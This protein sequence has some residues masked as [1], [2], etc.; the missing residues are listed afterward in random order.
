MKLSKKAKKV[1]LYGTES[2]TTRQDRWIP[3][4]KFRLFVKDQEGTWI[5]ISEDTELVNPVFVVYDAKKGYGFV[6][7]HNSKLCDFT[8]AMLF[9]EDAIVPCNLICF[10]KE[11]DKE[12]FNILKV[13]ANGRRVSETFDKFLLWADNLLLHSN[14]LGDKA[15]AVQM[16]GVDDLRKD[17]LGLY[18][19][20]QD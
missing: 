19:G 8:D 3:I 5:Q 1:F 2:R 18:G 14:L 4:L 10:T 12:E 9:W 16:I 6:Q 7:Q 17:A 15:G 11:E 20:E 13:S